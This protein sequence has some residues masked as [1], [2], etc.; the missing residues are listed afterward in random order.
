MEHGLL[1]R[2]VGN[3][4]PVPKRR[5]KCPKRR[6]RPA[7]R[8]CRGAGR[9]RDANGAFANEA[10]R[11]M[12]LRRRAG[13]PSS[14]DGT[15]TMKSWI[16]AD[17][18]ALAEFY[19]PNFDKGALP[20]H[21]NIEAVGKTQVAAALDREPAERARAS[22]AKSS[23]QANYCGV[24]IRPRRGA[25]APTANGCSRH[26]RRGHRRRS[27]MPIQRGG[28]TWR[29]RA[30]TRPSCIHVAQKPGIRPRLCPSD[31]LKPLA[32]VCASGRV[33]RSFPR[34][35]QPDGDR[36]GEAYGAA[37]RPEDA[38][39]RPLSR[40]SGQRQARRLRCRR[41]G[42]S[43]AFRRPASPEAEWP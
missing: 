39:V 30:S 34:R 6:H 12:A 5:F 7:T 14:L 15:Q 29:L 4:S 28:R 10:R 13:R 20:R 2:Q 23:M 1:R 43:P 37:C 27:V 19:G 3:V 35:R 26:A 41:R 31:C 21:S 16:V 42:G 17:A 8:R 9:R 38:P 33:R 22:T 32:R 18:D 25:A 36:R 40:R 24:S 11:Q